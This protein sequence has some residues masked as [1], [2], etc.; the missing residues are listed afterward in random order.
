MYGNYSKD[1]FKKHRL[2]SFFSMV[3][4]PGIAWYQ[5]MIWCLNFDT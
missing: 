2:G 3:E 1:D 5:V 4:L